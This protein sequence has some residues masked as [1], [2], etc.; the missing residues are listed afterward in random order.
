MTIEPWEAFLA[1]ALVASDLTGA[2]Q[3]PYMPDVPEPVD[4]VWERDAPHVIRL[5]AASARG[6]QTTI[7]AEMRGADVRGLLAAAIGLLGGLAAVAVARGEA[8]D[9]EGVFERWTQM[10]VADTG[11]AS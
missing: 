1:G 6:D 3:A 2:P 9:V 7:A 4:F 11:P 5:S 8:Q 10:A